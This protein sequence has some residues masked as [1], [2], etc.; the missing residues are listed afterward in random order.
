MKQVNEILFRAVCLCAAALLLVASLLCSIRVTA[1]NDM[2]ARLERENA[3]LEA[4]IAVLAARAE[5]R[6]SLE[7]LER[8]AVEKLGMQ[9]L[10]PGQVIL[11]ETSER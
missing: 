11:I 4:E 1:V 7:E 9:R 5:S 8:Y 6:L 3:A 2:A 10:S